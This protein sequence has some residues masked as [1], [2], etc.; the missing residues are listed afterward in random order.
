MPQMSPIKD[1]RK[2]VIPGSNDF[3]TKIPELKYQQEWV[4]KMDMDCLWKMVLFRQSDEEVL[5][6]NLNM[7]EC[8]NA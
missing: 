6:E 8:E 7:M 5:C 3:S 4:M 2:N 1:N